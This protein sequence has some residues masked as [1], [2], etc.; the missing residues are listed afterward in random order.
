[1]TGLFDIS[2]KTI[3]VTGGATGLGRMMAE[4]LV[5]AG[6]DVLVTSRNADA[7]GDAAREMSAWGRCEGIGANLSSAEAAT[8]L[9]AEV[10]A[11]RKQLHVLV[12]NAGRTWGAPLESFPD[13]A[14]NSIMT[15]NVQAP[16][17]LVRD[18]LPLLREGATEADPARVLNVGSMAGMVVERINAYSYAASKAAIHHLSKVMAADLAGDNVAVN[19][20]APGY[21]PTRMMAHIRD[22]DEK[23]AALAGRVPLGRVGHPDDIAGLCV[24]LAS[25]ASAYMTGALIPVDG[26]LSGCR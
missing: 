10:K 4:G 26:G 23:L 12:N 15:V 6:A 8:A 24:F 3:L 7:A 5:R 9:A 18:L 19:T 11:R 1:M 22:D 17:T 25:R 2:G 13:S 21:F 16:F 20:I 14:W